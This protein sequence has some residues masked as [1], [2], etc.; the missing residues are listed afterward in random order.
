MADFVHVPISKVLFYRIKK[1]AED[2]DLAVRDILEGII[3]EYLETVARDICS[4]DDDDDDDDEELYLDEDEEVGYEN[5]DYTYDDEISF[6]PT[7]T[8]S[9]ALTVDYD[10]VRKILG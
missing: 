7:P 6:V 3:E 5:E 2:D 1:V 4:D 8:P 9:F 10:E